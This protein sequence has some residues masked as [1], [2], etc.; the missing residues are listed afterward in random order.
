[1]EWL[2]PLTALYAALVT[3]PL[4][5]FLYFLKLKRH[6]Q[7]VS[8]TLLWQRAIR[9]LQVNAPF[10]KLRHNIL[11]FLQL[12]I[13]ISILLAIAWP[14]LAMKKGPGKRYVLLIDRSASMNT[15]DHDPATGNAGK[16][17]RL[18]KAKE[19]AKTFV[20][21]MKNKAVFSLKDD[22]DKAMII[23]F[24]E[25]AKV[26]CNFTSDKR[27]LNKAIDSII[28]G[29]GKSSL[30][31][32][33]IVA[34][35]FSQTPGGEADY[36]NQEQPAALELFSDG[37]INDLQGITVGTNELTYHSI[38]V[39]ASQNAGITAM[40]ALRSYENP[41]DIEVFASVSN[42]GD[43]PITT[44][45]QLGINNDVKA[46]KSITIPALTIN[47]DT[48]KEE[49]GK[50]S[51]N[52]SLSQ[53][54]SG[55]LEIKL[56]LDDSLACDNAA[57]AIISPPK[58]L[59]VLLVTSNNPALEA[60]LKAC[61][62]AKFEVQTPAQ[63][64]AMDQAAASLDNPYDV[65][66]LDN[67]VNDHLP[68]GRYIVFGQ[69]PGNIDVN[70]PEMLENQVI[71]DWRQKHPVLNY[72]NLMNLFA[73]KCYKLDLPRDAD[74]IAEF[75]KTPAMA[76]VQRNGSIFLLAGFDIME[77]NWPFEPGFVLFCY[78]AT[79]YLGMQV[80]QE[81]KNDL[82]VGD[83]IIVE[84]LEPGIEAKVTAPD[85][86]TESIK[87]NPSGTIRFADTSHVGP[88]SLS[89]SDGQPRLYAVNLLDSQES[90]IKPI[91]KLEFSNSQTVEAQ[92][93]DISRANMPLWPFLVGLAL[94]LACLEWVVYNFKVR[95]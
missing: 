9:D 15:I 69:P 16:L 3:L 2:T 78:N 53:I 82:N 71:I 35:A 77:T 59:S 75:N 61:P 42:Y 63:F 12:L 44:D 72:V 94:L 48:K 49:P 23:A 90:N 88:Y 46:V 30:S 64:D 1:M 5:L 41:D 67:H 70:T 29:H 4:L 92:K 65:I 54:K 10:Q 58:K 13:L 47:N 22:S 43:K 86:E 17:S 7:I 37:Q 83:P 19:Q 26:M 56:L 18:D 81:Q 62:L 8:S 31:E 20:E 38:G 51:V 28:T 91:E 68:K 95:I 45:L 76:I 87:A 36:L 40:Q 60:A 74:M 73:A 84:G 57:W 33:V 89:I 14:I 93:A 55:V 80:T 50:T 27:Q 25:H 32:T 79:S 85:K 66:V 34:R 11:L 24:D 39:Q 21:S 6:E 52:F